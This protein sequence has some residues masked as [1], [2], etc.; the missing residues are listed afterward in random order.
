MIML[1]KLIGIFITAMGIMELLNP[2]MAKRM[3]VFWR[4]GKNIYIGG[5]IR[6]LVGV[7]FLY[8]APQAKF[9]EVIFMLGILASLAGLIIFLLWLEMTRAMID[10]WDKKPDSI[11]RLVSLLTLAFGVLIIY[12]A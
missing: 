9:P 2:K 11:V 3:L 1:I 10:W 5:L 8:Y 7:I 4:Q 12:A 6:V